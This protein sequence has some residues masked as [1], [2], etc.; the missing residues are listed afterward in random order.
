MILLAESANR[1][2]KGGQDL[3]GGLDVKVNRNHFGRQIESF[4]ANLT[5][6]FLQSETSKGVPAAKTDGLRS[7]EFKGVFIRA[8]IVEKIL[9]VTQGEQSNEDALEDIVN[10]PSKS[11]QAPGH[12]AEPVTI[13]GTLP[14]R[15]AAVNGSM[16]ETEQR[17]HVNDIVAVRQGNVFGTSF[18]PELTND[19]RIHAW[20]LN[21]VRNALEDRC[22]HDR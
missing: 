4:E 14:G 15:S 8:P 9:P 13:M 16:Q 19:A 6:P 21:E 17:D 11:A 2:K 12:S 22:K 7:L 5:L 20:W 3:I 18:H 10:A 1:T